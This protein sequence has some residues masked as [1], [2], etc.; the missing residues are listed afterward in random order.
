[1][2]THGLILH[3]HRDIME[4]LQTEQRDTGKTLVAE[5]MVTRA[6]MEMEHFETRERSQAGH[7][8]TK[9]LI[10]DEH[11]TTRA[12][13][14]RE[15]METRKHIQAEND[16]IRSLMS[17]TEELDIIR[18]VMTA[19]MANGGNH[20]RCMKGTRQSILEEVEKWRLD[21][22]APQILWLADVA[23]AGKSTIAKEVAEKWKL[24]GCLAGRFFFS[25]DAE[26]TRTPKYFFSTI[27]QQGLAHLNSNVRAAVALGIRSL[28]NPVS[29][30]LEE[31]CSSI[32]LE[33]LK[34]TQMVVV[35][36]L[37]AL[38]ECEPQ[39]CQQL[40]HVL[41][42]TILNIPH[43]KLFITSRP[44]PHVREEL[45]GVTYQEL[46]LRLDEISNSRDVE[47]FMKDQLIKVSLTEMQVSRLVDHAGG[48]FIWAR[49]VCDLLKRS[50]GSKASFIDR[51]LSQ[52]FQE[53]N[54]IY[55]IALEQAIGTNKAKETV[56]AYLDVL[57]MIVAAFEP[58]TPKTI[59]RLLGIS[60]S[61]EIVNDLGSVL[62]CK[63]DEAII[64]MLHPTFREFLLDQTGCGQYYVD[65]NAAHDLVTR[66]CLGVMG[67]ELE[68]DKCKLYNI[69]SIG[70]RSLPLG[71]YGE[72]ELPSV[73]KLE[74]LCL[75]RTSSA[76]RYSCRFWGEHNVRRCLTISPLIPMIEDFFKSMLLNW[77]YMVS[78][79][80][81]LD[82][83]IT[84]L[85]RL[86]STKSVC[87]SNFL[88]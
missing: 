40:L 22:H 80:G 64:R 83:A 31:Q 11:A 78:V 48:L 77:M 76:L 27:A 1:M 23:E 79:Q 5:H 55:R 82:E 30:A 61:M 26:E 2:D 15:H 7:N 24:Q 59:N 14:E 87:D 86:M 57:K 28:I 29:A 69:T 32:F 42:P 52:N 19:S 45:V 53:M 49:T 43:L 74:K 17:D 33:P 8:E 38:D 84:M 10:S 65:I 37:D 3:Y 50:R 68:Y 13:Q 72:S 60:D 56:E 71:V 35:L 51:I 70:S 88:I 39:T 44:E 12:R 6:L 18:G 34:A 81:A 20:R 36:V 21:P 67:E 58:M 54:S 25:R 16:K 4:E 66:A 75:E 47:L 63:G 73:E 62:E 46:S 9:A 41:L 85:Q